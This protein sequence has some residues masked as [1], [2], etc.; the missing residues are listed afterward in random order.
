MA[1][2]SSSLIEI[3]KNF[4]T[5]IKQQDEKIECLNILNQAPISSLERFEVYRTAYFLRIKE[6]LEQD[7]SKVH[8]LLGKNDFEECCYDFVK[9]YPSN[10]WSLATISLNFPRY[11][12][13]SKLVLKYDYLPDLALFELFHVL[14]WEISP[15]KVFDFSVIQNLNENKLEKFK[16]KCS[17]SVFFMESHWPIHDF[18]LNSVEHDGFIFEKQNSYLI[19]YQKQGEVKARALLKQQWELLK[20]ISQGISIGDI[21][22]RFS[23]LNEEEIQRWF[24]DFVV[25]QIIAY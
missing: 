20:E 10:Y 19:I 6:A 13:E 8:K 23:Y 18:N 5:Y 3:Q 21:S 24:T 17:S 9:K 1:K 7:F 12:S 14:C 11:L 22:T 15:S 25:E 4:A 16:I 2:S